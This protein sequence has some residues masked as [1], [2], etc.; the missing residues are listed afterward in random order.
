[1]IVDKAISYV[2]EFFEE[3]YSGHDFYHTLRVYNLAKYIANIEKCD[4]R[5]N[6]SISPLERIESLFAFEFCNISL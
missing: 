2:K 5:G 1:M 3:D 6:Q 4:K